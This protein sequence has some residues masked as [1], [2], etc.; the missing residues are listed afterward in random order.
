VCRPNGLVAMA[1]WTPTGFAGQMFKTNAKHVAPPP[2]M[3]SPALWGDEETVRERLRDGFTDLKMTRRKIIFK[4]P[5]SPGEVVEH[6]RTYFGPTKMAF[7]TL[8]ENGQTALQHDL[9]QLWTENNRATDGT[10]EIESEYLE[11]IAVR[12]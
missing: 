11:V 7:Q 5:L 1:N 10:T 9:E 2:G 3:P 12:A 4:F 8:D 6:F